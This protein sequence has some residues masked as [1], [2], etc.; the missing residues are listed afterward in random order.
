M[1]TNAARD[2]RQNAPFESGRWFRVDP[3]SP[4][5][6][7]PGAT[8]FPNSVDP[9]NSKPGNLPL[10]QPLRRVIEGFHRDS[11]VMRVGMQ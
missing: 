10:L 1:H 8:E 11:H 4:S 6:R 5:F 7:A 2:C 9:A 3:G